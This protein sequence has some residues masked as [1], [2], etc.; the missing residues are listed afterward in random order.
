MGDQCP[1]QIVA[2]HAQ[3]CV[4]KYLKGFLVLR[5]VDFPYTHSITWLFELCEENG[6]SLSD[7]REAE[8]LTAYATATRYPSQGLRIS[9]A[10]AERAIELANKVRLVMRQMLDEFGISNLP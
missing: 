6:A 7:L 10:Q 2:Y 8:E 5:G 4:E 9:K 3:Q 1:P